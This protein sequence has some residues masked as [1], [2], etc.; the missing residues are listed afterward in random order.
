MAR[1]LR[2][3]IEEAE[4]HGEVRRVSTEVHWNEEMTAVAYCDHKTKGAPSLL[5]EN[6]TDH[7]NTACSRVLYNMRGSSPRRFALIID[8]DPSLT[9][10]EL[11]DLG[12]TRFDKK[13]SANGIEPALARIYENS[14]YGDEVDLYDF[15]APVFWPHD[16]GRY[17]GTAN[18]TISRN[19]ETGI[20]NVGT[21]RHMVHNRDETTLHVAPGKG[22]R[23]HYE[24]QWDRGKSLDI[25]VAYGIQPE[26]LIAA[27]SSVSEGENEYEYAGGLRGSAFET[28][29]GEH[30]GLPIPAHAEIVAEGRLEPFEF[31]DE[32]PFGEFMGY[33]GHSAPETPVFEIDALH[34][35]DDPILT[36]SIMAPYPGGD[37]GVMN[38]IKKSGRTWEQ[39]DQVGV[40]GLN[41]VYSPPECNEL[42]IVSLEQQYAGHVQEV[43]GLTA[44]L[45][46]RQKIAIAVDE[47]I[48]PTDLNEVFWALDTRF[49]PEH[50]LQMLTETQGFSLDPALPEDM[51]DWGSKVLIDATKNYR[52]YDKGEFPERTVPRRETYEA[53]RERWD[54]FDL[55][56]PFPELHCFV[57]D[58]FEDDVEVS[59]QTDEETG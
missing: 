10:R 18:A 14:V 47:D 17:I 25:A 30:S 4:V 44:H 41:G 19:P 29:E 23:R 33:Y 27:G 55:E 6:I 50:N 39:L 48:E 11:I 3:W 49:S 13:Q 12:R 42:T 59:K 40:D 58:D 53:I 37:N 5:F 20:V 7:Q 16:G 52:Y 21:Y 45:T 2:D 24:H 22:L 9:L 38:A 31:G 15:P 57:E 36:A 35:R 54:E 8:E 1:D 46:G 43:L 28:V 26:L 56:E 32:G 34:H 51:R